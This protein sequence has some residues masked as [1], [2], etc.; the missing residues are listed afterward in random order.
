MGDNLYNILELGIQIV[1]V[2]YYNQSFIV[3]FFMIPYR[4]ERLFSHNR[5]SGTPSFVLVGQVCSHLYK[6]IQ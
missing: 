4:K 6:I 5:I 2:K 3:P 1:F